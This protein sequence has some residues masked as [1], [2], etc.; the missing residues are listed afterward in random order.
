MNDMERTAEHK[1]EIFHSLIARDLTKVLHMRRKDIHM[2]ACCIGIA[3][4]TANNLNAATAK[5]PE[6]IEATK[7]PIK[8]MSSEREKIMA[9]LE[10]AANTIMK[11]IN[12]TIVILDLL[13]DDAIVYDSTMA[14]SR[15]T[16]CSSF[17]IW[18]T[19]FGI[20]NGLIQS[21][22]EQFY[23]WDGRERIIPEW[24]MDLSL[25]DA[26]QFSCVPAYQGL[27]IKIGEQSMREWVEK[28]N[29]GDKDISSGIDVFWLPRKG[30]KSIKISPLEQAHLIKKLLKRQLGFGEKSLAILENLM[31]HKTTAAG[32]MYGKT[33]SG[34]NVD[35][36][37]DN[38]IGWYVGYVV[39][40]NRKF[41][42]ACLMR[43]KSATGRYARDLVERIFVEC[44]VI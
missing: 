36:I 23:K 28:I 6:L 24:N 2:A 11:D 44:G 32:S 12:G 21:E 1:D 35:D 5:V 10:N 43:N 30:K 15:T 18:N 19:L 4:L 22:A 39:G 29:Y 3:L 34:H 20:E 9:Q 27:A 25:K 16:P 41:A 7:R 38:D 14:K 8:E 26:F 13:S 40:K 17:K 33:G 31:H 37:Q 42:F